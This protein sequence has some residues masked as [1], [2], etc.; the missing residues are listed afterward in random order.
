MVS[1]RIIVGLCQWVLA[2]VFLMACLPKIAN[3]HEFAVS[4]FRY[5]VLPYSLVNIVAIFLPWVEGVAALYLLFSVRG[6]AAAAL[7]IFGMLFV[8]TVAIAVD[9]YR[10]IDIACG[11]FSVSGGARVGWLSIVRNVVLM[12]MAI[13]VVIGQT[14]EPADQSRR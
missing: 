8:F 14:A 12:A 1:K 11:C 7:I 6:R 13:V 3:P 9:V 2:L 10:G 4:V 5:Q